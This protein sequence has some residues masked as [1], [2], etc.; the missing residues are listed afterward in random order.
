MGCR[1][2]LPSCRS[3]ALLKAS[4]GCAVPVNGPI[5]QQSFSLSSCI[6]DATFSHSVL[7]NPWHLRLELIPHK[8]KF[9][10]G[11]AAGHPY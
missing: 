2:S 8:S 10:M 1:V 11:R 3:E 4:R 7:V 6:C 5:R 9:S